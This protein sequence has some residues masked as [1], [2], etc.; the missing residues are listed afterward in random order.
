MKQKLLTGIAVVTIMGALSGC[1]TTTP[2]KPLSFNEALSGRYLD[3]SNFLTSIG[4]QKT[5]IAYF[6]AKSADALNGVAPESLSDRDILPMYQAE[7]TE[8]RERLLAALASPN[9]SRAPIMAAR[10][11]VAFDCWVDRA[12]EK[13]D[14]EATAR[15]RND[16]Y[17]TLAALENNDASG[18]AVLIF[19]KFNSTVVDKQQ[20]A[21]IKDIAT[22]YA[23]GNITGIDVIGH[24]DRK[25]SAAYNTQLSKSRA[26]AVRKA[27]VANGV[28]KES[29]AVRAAGEAAPLI[30]T[31][32]GVAEAQNRRVEIIMY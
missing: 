28:S 32:D 4:A 17:Q 19:F 13:Y 12:E 18:N 20:M 30:E 15:C 1:M 31:K 2:E 3:Y 25:G 10:L 22:D 16:F 21:I 23:A 29:V 5:D 27:L 9:A 8:A 24:T 6:Q 11:Q 26:E 7:L 14:G